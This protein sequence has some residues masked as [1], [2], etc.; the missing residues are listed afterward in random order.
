M[1]DAN[2]PEAPKEER[3]ATFVLT[4]FERWALPRMA[5]ALPRWIVPDHLTAIGVLGSTLIA[6]GYG[7]SNRSPGWLWLSNA[8]LVI[9]WF[10][11]SLDG[12]LART[13]K[14]ERPRYGFYLDHLTDAYST[15]AIGLGLG[16]SPFMLLSVGLAIVIGYLVL[17]INVYLETHVFGKFRYG[18]GVMGP[19]EARLVLMAL[20]ILALVIGPLRFQILGIGLTAFDVLGILAAL[21]MAGLLM[22]RVIRNLG[23]LARDEPQRR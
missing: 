8:G 6:A 23:D 16:F 11:D 2:R 3:Q 22:R 9:H 12:T 20:N 14:I 4:R 10:G 13:R 7:L 5:L 18:Y 1:S 17:S 15:T 21:G 19:T